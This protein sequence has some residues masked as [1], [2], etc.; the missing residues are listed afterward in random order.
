MSTTDTADGLDNHPEFELSYLYDDTD[1]PTEV[2]VFP[3]DDGGL[4]TQW[5][6]MDITHAVALEDTR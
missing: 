5:I 4:S 6:S 1:D 3:V 2:T